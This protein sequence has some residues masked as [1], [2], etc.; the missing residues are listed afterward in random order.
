MDVAAPA[1]GTVSDA[2][3]ELQAYT[4]AHGD[5]TFIHQHV[6]DAGAAQH[7]D[8]RTKPIGLTFALVG[9]YLHV[10]HGWT[11]R[12]VQRAHQHLAQ[13]KQAWPSFALPQLRG[14]MR[15]ADVVAVLPGP[16]R[17]RAIDAWCESVWHAYRDHHHAV[18]ELLRQQGIDPS[19]HVFRAGSNL[20]RNK[21][22]R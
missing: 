21:L 4:L 16:E 9:L 15:A 3:N 11:G 7:A 17:D 20:L 10:E 18:A 8:E 19:W 22:D 12:Q 1:A 6:V 13:R 14:S 2:Y 5:P